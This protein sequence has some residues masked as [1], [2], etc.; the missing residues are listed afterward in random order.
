MTFRKGLSTHSQMANANREQWNFS[1]AD[2]KHVD[3]EDAVEY[4]L[5]PD[6]KEK[7]NLANH[8]EELQTRCFTF[9][10]EQCRSYIWHEDSI[11]LCAV[12]QWTQS[13]K[14]ILL[15][16]TVVVKL[17]FF[18]LSCAGPNSLQSIIS[19]SSIR[20]NSRH[21]RLYA[22][23][24]RGYG[25]LSLFGLECLSFPLFISTFCPSCRTS[26]LLSVI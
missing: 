9:L 8:L 2:R 13:G 20:N 17:M 6:V 12:T 5:F 11:N 22:A 23:R 16:L 1:M 26:E 3:F 19:F 15:L 24:R 10:N 7:E 14:S 21:W 18:Q 4:F 25:L